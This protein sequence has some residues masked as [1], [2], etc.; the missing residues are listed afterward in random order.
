MTNNQE[1]NS[2]LEPF[3]LDN[4]SENANNV[5]D[6]LI[7]SS[8]VSTNSEDGSE[9]WN[10]FLSALADVPRSKEANDRRMFPVDT[11]VIESLKLCDIQK[12]KPSDILNAIL[13]CFI[14]K[15]RERL[16]SMKKEP[17]KTLF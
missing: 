16:I 5:I 12:R 6:E 8:D 2:I 15:H 7:L 14:R 3:K 17:R 10:D 1:F 11:A 4:N 9:E 13:I